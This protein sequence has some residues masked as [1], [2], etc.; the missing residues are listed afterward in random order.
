MKERTRAKVVQRATRTS[1]VARARTLAL[2]A[3]GAAVGAGVALAAGT[4]PTGS[5]RPLARPHA[6]AK[7][8]CATCHDSPPASSATST[9]ASAVSNAAPQPGPVFAAAGACKTCHGPTQHASVRSAHRGLAGRGELTCATCHPA[10]EGAQGVTFGEGGSFVRWGAGA[11]VKGRGR[12]GGATAKTGATVPLVSLAACAKCH[13]PTSARDPIAACVPAEVRGLANAKANAN[14]EADPEENAEARAALARTAS[15]CFDEHRSVGSAEGRLVAWEAAREAATSSAWVGGARESGSPWTP[16]GGALAGAVALGVSAALVERRKRNKA[17]A[18]A[19][20]AKAPAARQRLP[21][22]NPG[23]CLGCYACV[24]ACPFDVLAIERYVAVVV[25][26]DE[27]CGVVLC[28]QVCPNGSLTI[29]EGEPVLDRPAVDEHLESRDVPG[30][31]LAGDLT[32]LPLIKN[33]INQGV[34]TIDRIA[35]TLPR[36]RREPFDVVVVGAGPAGLSAALRAQER[37][38]SCVVVE[39][40]TVAASVKSFPRDKIVYDPPLDL[41]VEGELWLKEATKEEL[42]AQWTRIVRARAI[43]VRE[44]R[45]VTDIA[46][47][48]SA[49]EGAFV[50]TTAKTDGAPEVYRASRAVLAIGRRGTPREIELA[51]EAGAE[52]RVSYALAD[53]RSFAGKRVVIAGLGDT[54]MEAAIAIARQPETSVTISY[55]GATFTRGKARNISEV[56]DLVA[57]GRLRI[58]FET[59][60]VAVTR[61]S[62]TIAGVTPGKARRTLQAEGL[63]VL[64]GGLPSWDLLGRCGIRHP[65]ALVPR[66]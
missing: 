42:V 40:A 24:D 59:V 32:G 53:A 10:H 21:V 26:P 3:L 63:L 61:T 31:Y 34:R 2:A 25:R 36:K 9:A 41:P 50:I 15:L 51:V 45:R 29:T 60:P 11:E 56:R 38:L 28:E 1:D 27:C 17:P 65:Q 52:G 23:T 54:A 22:I 49:P 55:R 62:I 6:N 37:G 46:R 13:D 47:D 18:P 39:Q 64:V 8:A 16:L 4:T 58:L 14:G 33:A 44:G 5:E 35:S 30:L 20:Q 12:V 43:D 7:I 48:P 57:K 66:A 19:A